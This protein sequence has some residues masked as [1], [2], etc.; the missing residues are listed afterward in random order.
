M[1]TSIIVIT[2]VLIHFLLPILQFSGENDS[3]STQCNWIF[4]YGSNMDETHVEIKKNLTVSGKYLFQS[5]LIRISF[6][7]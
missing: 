7:I 4:G 5:E 2:I 1:F 3:K 6:K